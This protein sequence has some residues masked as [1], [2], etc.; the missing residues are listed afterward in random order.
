[1]KKDGNCRRKLIENDYG[2]VGIELEFVDKFEI[3]RE[4]GFR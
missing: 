4:S 2:R 1:L 3:V